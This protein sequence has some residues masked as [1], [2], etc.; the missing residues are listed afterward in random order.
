MRGRTERDGAKQAA[1][2][3]APY[4]EGGPAMTRQTKWQLRHLATLS[5]HVTKDQ[6]AAF[7]AACHA[8]ASRPYVELRKF[9]LHYTEQ[10]CPKNGTMKE[11]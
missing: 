7:R 3:A 10:N 1:G 9:V 8:Q 5:T 11:E 2:A 6:A 4:Q